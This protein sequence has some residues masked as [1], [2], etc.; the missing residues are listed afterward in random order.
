[1]STF[2]PSASFH[3]GPLT[4]YFYGLLITFG[5]LMGYILAVKRARIYNIPVSEIENVFLLTIPSAIVGARL[6]HVILSWNYYSSDLR[7]IL[8]VRAGGLAI[9]GGIFASILVFI[10]YAK[11]RRINLL[12]LLDLCAPSLAL[13]QAIGRWGNFFNQELYGSPTSLPW[14]ITIDPIHRI[15]G[16]YGYE[17]YHPTFLYESLLNLAV[18]LG[19]IYLAR[20][21]KLQSRGRLFFLYLIAY[22]IVRFGLEFI[23]ID[24]QTILGPFK[25]AQLTSLALIIIGSVG[26]YRMSRQK[27]LKKNQKKTI[28]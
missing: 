19:L 22:G 9:H 15:P 2:I 23:R 17:F 5:I 25:F 28:S 4:F 1:M 11:I 6:Y 14:K 10:I 21:W 24:E 3:L 12:A 27:V 7:E 8:N 26:V 20:R 16:Y 18:C 13:G